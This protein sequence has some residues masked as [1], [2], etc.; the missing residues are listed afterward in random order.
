MTNQYRYQHVKRYRRLRGALVAAGLNQDDL[1]DIL[2]I[3]AASVSNRLRGQQ[4]W[5]LNEMYTVLACLGVEKPEAVLGFY[6]PQDGQDPE[7]G[8]CHVD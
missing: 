1:G 5:R 8:G 7:V 4:S 3:S 6:F 2:H